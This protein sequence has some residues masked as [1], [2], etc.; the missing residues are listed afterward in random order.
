MPTV[1]FKV[2]ATYLIKQLVVLTLKG[3]FNSRSDYGAVSIIT[4]CLIKVKAM[5]DEKNNNVPKFSLLLLDD[6]E[7]ILNS[8]N[9]LLRKEY[10]IISFTS[11]QEALDY[12]ADNSV[13]LIMTDM[14]MPAMDGAEFLALARAIQPDPIRILLTGYSDIDSTIK[15][16]NDG[17]I[18]TYIAKPWNNE[19]LK[20][21]LNK[22]AD[23]YELK[24]DKQNLIENLAKT[25]NK[26]AELNGSLEQKVKQRTNELQSSK[27]KLNEN[28]TNQKELLHDVL[29][30]MAATIEFRTGL[31][32]GH[33]KRI[34]LQCRA[35]ATNLALD[36]LHCKRIYFCA[37]LHEVGVVGLSDEE[38]ASSNLTD[39]KLDEALAGHPEIG[40]KIVGRVKRFS[41]LTENIRHQNEN[42]DGT[43]IPDHL[44][45]ENIPI[46]ARIIRIVK[47]FDFL[48]AGRQNHKRMSINNAIAWIK[49]RANVW[50]D[51]KVIDVFVSLLV[52]RDCDDALEMEFSIGIERL[53]PGD[54]L[55][56]DLVLHNGNIMLTAG[57]EINNAMIEKLRQ[58]EQTNNTKVT[59]FTC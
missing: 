43:G 55:A 51:S 3:Y 20:L 59:L 34:A 36:D 14:R 45:G 35:V 48:I 19:E 9:R 7:Q 28:L 39:V 44:E 4:I 16:V 38:L 54:V 6:E 42:F 2:S 40:A 11:G 8:L 47:D 13:Q 41:S 58:Y 17:G 53:K 5:D 37:L 52:Q 31:S 22:A 23:Y 26:L 1:C 10:H 21:I 18:Y 49:E 57:Q 30:M 24:Q 27:Q 46:G 29:D 50:Y 56:E 33:S 32:A 25:N 12:L 15:A